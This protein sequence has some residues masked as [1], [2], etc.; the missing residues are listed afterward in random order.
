MADEE[1][2]EYVIIHELSHIKEHNHSDRFWALMDR[3][4][5]GKALQLRQALKSY[6]TCT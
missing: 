2:V 6:P 1:T 4:T 5:D 3:V